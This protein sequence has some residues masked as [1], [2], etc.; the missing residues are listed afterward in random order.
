M[1]LKDLYILHYFHVECSFESFKRTR[2]IN[3]VITALSE[4]TGVEATT[5]AEKSM[6]TKFIAGLDL[7]KS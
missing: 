5:D 2:D 3:N 6:I 7:Q 1:L 4:I